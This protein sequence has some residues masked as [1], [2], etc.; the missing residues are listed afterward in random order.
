M[1]NREFG[2]AP[3]VTKK[4]KEKK[5]KNPNT[6]VFGVAERTAAL[7]LLAIFCRESG[8]PTYAELW[9]CHGFAMLLRKTHS[10]KDRERSP[11][12][13]R[14]PLRVAALVL[15]LPSPPPQ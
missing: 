14:H 15:P 11:T 12:P 13:C 6:C 9:T 3:E 8:L 5:K 2:R 10:C 1:R 4:E 7:A